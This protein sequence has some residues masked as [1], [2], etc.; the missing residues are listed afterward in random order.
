MLLITAR[1]QLL[2]QP[3]TI[4]L[5]HKIKKMPI[6]GGW[7]TGAIKIK[8][9]SNMTGRF[10]D[11]IITDSCIVDCPSLAI[12]VRELNLVQLCLKPKATEPI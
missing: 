5:I 7:L 8:A 1:I 10:V 12:N 11:E 6:A 4:L 9:K 2:E 3:I